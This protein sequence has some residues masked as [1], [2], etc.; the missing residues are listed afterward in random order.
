VRLDDPYLGPFGV[1]VR[2]RPAAGP[3]FNVVR[4]VKPLFDAAVS[5]LH[6]H[7]DGST[8]REI[9]RRVAEATEASADEIA[10]LLGDSSSAAL[11]VVPR[12]IHLRGLG[13]QLCPADDRCFAGEMLVE[14]STGG[15][16][17]LVSC[18]VVALHPR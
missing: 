11:G 15:E 5:A 1:R 9:S 10:Q 17:H 13:S 7:G 4:L 6:A 2:V 16:S 8:L 14:D 12:L 18:D 3:A